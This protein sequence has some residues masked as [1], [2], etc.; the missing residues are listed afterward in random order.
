MKRNR[1]LRLFVDVK[2]QSSLSLRVVAYWIV[3]QA[4]MAS[5]VYA[6]LAFEASNGHPAQG[7]PWR[8]L[9]P[10]LIGSTVVLPLVLL[11]VLLFSNRFAGPLLRFRRHLQQLNNGEEVGPLRFRTG[12]HYL[13]LCDEFNRFMEKQLL[14]TVDRKTRNG[15]YEPELSQPVA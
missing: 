14:E 15:Y 7:S 8:F 13:D 9:V 12:D 4:T 11:D 5:V 10:A 2:L 3:C 6:I 1:R